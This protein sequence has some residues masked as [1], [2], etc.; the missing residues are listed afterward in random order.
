MNFFNELD[1]YDSNACLIDEN[2]KVFSYKDVLDISKK[3]S[4][5][6]K[7]RS[8]IFVLA[9]N[10]IEFVTSYI[11]FFAKGLVQML[12]D[13]KIEVNL[14]KNLVENYLPSY[15]FLPSSKKIDFK[16]YENF[17]DLKNHKILKI[18]KKVNYSIN[19]DLALMLSTS[20]STGS[21]KFVRL[22]YEN[23]NDNTKNIVRYLNIKENHRT[24]TT[25]PPHY[26]Y[27]L[28]II[29]THLYTGASIFVTN[30]KVV[31]KNFW[32]FFK[33]QKITSFGGVP[34]F[35]EIIKKL[36]FN[37]MHFTNLKYFTQAG[38]PL[39]RE[40]TKYFID[41]AKKNNTDFIIMYGQAE[42]TSRMAYL[43][44][45]ILKKKIG[46]IGMPIPGGKIRLQNEKSNND[47]K[48]EIIYEG[49]NVSMGYSTN[50]KDLK[51]GDENKGILRTGDLAVKDK[52]GYLF[53]T[54]RKSRNVKLFGHR[55]NLDEVEKILQKK[56]YNCLCLGVDN[57]I[58]IFSKDRKNVK[59]IPQFLSKVMN[60]H[61][62]CFKFIYIKSFPLSSNNKILYK[63][64]EQFI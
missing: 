21:K 51:K 11:G 49:K 1:K 57:K 20:G 35:Y 7:E 22:S 15:I 33:E 47:K 54:G 27:G 52:N 10:H 12:I 17:L 39:N 32:K 30:T 28:S 55:V 19:M 9:Q 46:S 53:I 48:G 24:V 43:P 8:L 31:E 44:Y 50:H 40:L 26:T 4:K 45:E 63:K 16:N 42:A 64:L 59:E 13:P 62:A 56:G 58:T 5:Y 6:L 34:Y 14:F 60:I 18:K 61:S 38:G 41:Y 29:N 36:N 25:M 23:I 3:T 2:N 37:K